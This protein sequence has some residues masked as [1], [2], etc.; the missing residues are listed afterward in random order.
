MKTFAIAINLLL[1]LI[2]SFANGKFIGGTISNYFY[3]RV[4]VSIP[5]IKINNGHYWSIKIS[6]EHGIF[7]LWSTCALFFTYI[8]QNQNFYFKFVDI[9]DFLKET[10]SYLVV[11]FVMFSSNWITCV[12]NRFWLKNQNKYTTK[13]FIL[14]LFCIYIIILFNIIFVLGQKVYLYGES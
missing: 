6:G 13:V 14:L 5:H 11:N 7:H 12:V 8:I 3:N 2:I 9:I 10:I 1:W 4:A